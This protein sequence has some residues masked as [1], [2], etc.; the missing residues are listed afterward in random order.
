MQSFLLVQEK[1]T[2]E[3][4]HQTQSYEYLKYLTLILY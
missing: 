4:K 1:I 3:A 2:K